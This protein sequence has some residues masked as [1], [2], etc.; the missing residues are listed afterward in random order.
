MYAFRPARPGDKK[1]NP[2]LYFWASILFV[3]FAWTYTSFFRR[4]P[5]I[6]PLSF[7]GG[8]ILYMLLLAFIA[9]LKRIPMLIPVEKR[10]IG[11]R[12][13][14]LFIRLLV[15]ILAF[16]LASFAFSFIT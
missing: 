13:N 7:I 15:V 5:F 9:Y 3:P 6:G 11:K 10:D 8:T 4:E 1:F 14:F 12:N 16:Y 2:K